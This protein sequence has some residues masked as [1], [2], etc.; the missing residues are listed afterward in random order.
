[1]KIIINI[2]YGNGPQRN[3][4]VEIIPYSI[5]PKG[6]VE[7]IKENPEED[8]LSFCLFNDYWTNNTR[9][10]VNSQFSI[11]LEKIF[12]RYQISKI[13]NISTNTYQFWLKKISFNSI[14]ELKLWV[15]EIEK[16][17]PYGE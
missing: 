2:K 1:M 12:E 4:F 14:K 6:V 17:L 8:F 3:K 5:T 15:D 16:H 11:F 10:S 9:E 13:K 7:L